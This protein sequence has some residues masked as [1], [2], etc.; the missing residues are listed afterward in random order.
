M[1]IDEERIDRR[2]GY[3]RSFVDSAWNSEVAEAEALIERIRVEL[4]LGRCDASTKAFYRAA[5]HCLEDVVERRHASE[6][7]D[8]LHARHLVADYIKVLL[9]GMRQ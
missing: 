6:G 8:R 7:K 2:F 9:E 3:L 1:P 5:V 4:M